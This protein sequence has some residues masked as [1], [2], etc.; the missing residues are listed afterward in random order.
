MKTYRF[1]FV[2][3]VPVDEARDILADAVEIVELFCGKAALKVDVNCRIN[4]KNRTCDISSDTDT[5]E[6]LV[7]LFSA[8]LIDQFDE[9][10]FAISRIETAE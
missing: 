7:K 10:A 6:M 8:M 9:E 4:S 2:K 3:E 5:G 1:T